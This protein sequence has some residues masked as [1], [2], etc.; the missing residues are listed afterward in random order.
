MEEQDKQ[1]IQARYQEEKE[2]GVKF[3][4]DIIYKDTLVAFSIFILL[5]GLAAFVG[6]PHEA[7]ADPGDTSYVPRPEWYFLFL[8]EMLKFFPGQIEFIG[9]V[10]IP[11]AA[12]LALFLLPFFDRRLK[13]HPLGRPAATGTMSAVVLLMI[14]LTAHSVMT[15]P[16]Q[17]EVTGASYRERLAAGEELYLTVCAECH[18]P[19]G[20]GGEVKGVEGLE[21]RVV[22]PINSHDFLYTRTDETIYNVID[23]GQPDLGM[24]PQG[25]A[26]GGELTAHEINAVVTFVRSWD[27]RIVVE[28]PK[29]AIPPLAEGE[30]PDYETH[31][32]PIF[33]RFCVACHRPG[34][35]Q[36][37]YVI[38][39]YQSVMTT[40]DHTPNVIGGDLSC[41]MLR[42][43]NREEIEAGGPMPP[44]RPLD[45]NKLDVIVRWIEAGA[46]P[47][48]PAQPISPTQVINTSPLQ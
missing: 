29:E 3:F 32:Q 36:Q 2:R 15:T 48:R 14:G 1:H 20:E 33:K 19:Q 21:G 23:Y 4:P 41:N 11:G 17:P 18:Q 10:V 13:R 39:D 47:V 44:T 28:V 40:G 7:P 42:M 38:S 46:L 45:S 30:V 9:T 26:N 34:K 16:P 31:V 6:V 22:D 5:V 37:N 27:D 24:P 12:I 35:A 25:L 43:L 8:F